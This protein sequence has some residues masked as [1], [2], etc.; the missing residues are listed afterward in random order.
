MTAPSVVL[1]QLRPPVSVRACNQREP[2]ACTVDGL[3]NADEMAQWISHSESRGYEQA[4]V[5]VGGGQQMEMLDVRNN[6]RYDI[7]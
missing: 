4:L 5:N 1:T 3:F 6:K 2:F 7:D